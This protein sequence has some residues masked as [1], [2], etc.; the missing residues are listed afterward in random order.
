MLR[1]IRVMRDRHVSIASVVSI[2][3]LQTKPTPYFLL[4]FTE[5]TYAPSGPVNHKVTVGLGG[6][7]FNPSNISAAIGDTVTFEFHPKAH[8]VTQSTFADPCTFKD[9]GIDTDL[10]PVAANVTSDFP[11]RQ[12]VING[13]SCF[14]SDFL[15]KSLPLSLYLIQ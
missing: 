7:V 5:P 13:V 2:H 8:S 12:I 6:L 4:S 15:S 1:L 9:G 3:T 11:T 10:I 14:P